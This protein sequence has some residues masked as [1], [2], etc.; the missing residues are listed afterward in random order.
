MACSAD[1][2]DDDS[3]WYGSNSREK[4]ILCCLPRMSKKNR[5]V[6]ARKRIKKKY[7]NEIRCLGT[8]RNGRCK[9]WEG[10]EN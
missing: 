4:K 5:D 10:Q 7:G 3:K 6:D 2:I 8:Q 1:E 9:H